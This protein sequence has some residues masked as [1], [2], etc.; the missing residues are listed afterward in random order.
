V[1]EVEM[2]GFRLGPLELVIVL[3]IVVILFGGRLGRL[4][5]DL[6]RSIREFR[7]GLKGDEEETPKDQQ[8]PDSSAQS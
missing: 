5:G 1:L 4:G 7:K 6:G 8:P 3:V 2:A